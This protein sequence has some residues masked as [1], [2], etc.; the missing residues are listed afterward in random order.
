MAIIIDKNRNLGTCPKSLQD[1]FLKIYYDHYYKKGE[2]P[3]F[4]ISDGIWYT[5]RDDKGVVSPEVNRYG[6]IYFH[7]RN[8]NYNYKDKEIMEDV[9]TSAQKQAE[10]AG[11]TKDVIPYSYGY[12][13][14]GP[15]IQ[16][17]IRVAITDDTA[18]RAN[19]I[20][21]YV[22]KWHEKQGSDY[23]PYHKPIFF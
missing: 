3:I 7:T 1:L 10:E 6:D 5:W 22:E 21:S 18:C 19:G 17:A 13:P 12:S 15:D 8:L 20:L 11:I 9:F 16:K 2:I 23:I 14:W 4:K